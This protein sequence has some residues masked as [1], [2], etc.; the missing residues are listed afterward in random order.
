MRPAPLDFDVPAQLGALRR[1][2]HS[3]TRNPDDAE[4]LVHD[5][6][7]RAYERQETFQAS[8]SLLP[9]LL[10]IVHNAFIDRLRRDKADARKRAATGDFLVRHQEPAQDHSVRLKQVRETFFSLPEDQRAALHLV[11]VEGLTYAETADLLDVPIGTV[12]SRVNRARAA[13]RALEQPGS[14]STPPHLKIVGGR[15]E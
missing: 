14:A 1:Y 3:L 15:D 7:V 10:S 6:L 2:A 8:C 5:A 12:L 13:L 9:W 11:G 4:D